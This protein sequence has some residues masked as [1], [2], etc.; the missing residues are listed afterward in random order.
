MKKILVLYYSQTGQCRQILESILAPL[1]GRVELVFRPIEPERDFPFPWTSYQF[2]DAMPEAVMGTPIKLRPL[3]TADQDA[4]LVILGYQPWFL[5]PSIPITSFLKSEPARILL[6]NKPVVTVAGTRN[7]WLNAQ[8]KV[9]EYLID[10]QARLVGQIVLEDQ[11]PNLVSLFTIIRWAFK[12][13]KEAS[14]L[15]PE[16]GVSA[17]SI[18]EAHRFGPCLE[19]SLEKSDYGTLQEDLL[20]LGAV[21]LK[22]SLIL[23]EKRGIKNFRFWG[24]FIAKKG[25]PGDRRRIPRLRLF[26]YLLLIGIFVLSPITS[27]T[28]QIQTRIRKKSLEKDRA[29]FCRCAY[30]PGRI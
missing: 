2:F 23:L 7:M 28:G 10:N 13:Q 24:P 20:A 12:G 18:K 11:H 4:D 25:G 14:G 1:K 19:G 16:A 29:Y 8:E 26:H 15:L 17:R 3:S 22:T 9:K 21:P 30:E 6:K 27:L 5:H